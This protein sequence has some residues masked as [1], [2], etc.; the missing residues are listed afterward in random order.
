MEDVNAWLRHFSDLGWAAPRYCGPAD[1]ETRLADGSNKDY[2]N[3]VRKPV[4]YGEGFYEE[5]MGYPLGNV[6]DI[7]ELDGYEWPSPDWFDTG[8]FLSC[9]KRMDGEEGVKAIVLGNA[10]IFE[11]SWYMVGFEKMLIMLTEKP[12]LAYEIMRRVTDFYVDYFK[13]ALSAG[14]GRV[15]ITFMA[16]D[17][18]QQNGLIMSLSMWERLIKPHHVRINRVLHE[19]G[20]K[21]MYHS[22]GA[23]SKAVPSL[24][25]MGIDVLEA[26]Q[27]DAAG[28]DPTDLKEN[29]G[30][31]LCFHG[32]V[33]VQST[34]PFGSPE[35]VRAE[36]RE[37]VR[38]LGK[39]GGY[40]LAPSHAVQAGTPPENVV[41]FLEASREEI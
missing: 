38:V 8:N 39:N 31:Q 40:I 41:A 9:L 35:K 24:I 10:N 36:V 6:R 22:D 30:G 16:D 13:K 27:F 5:I 29:Y 7:S 15:D 1:R 18:G 37:R 32:G 33:S 3:V 17:I 20:V 2:W 28:M 25:G 12:E 4:S 23:I 34:L 19:F 21:I 11:T 26:L 14:R